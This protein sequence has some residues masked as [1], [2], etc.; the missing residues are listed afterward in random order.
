MQQIDGQ[1]T[2]TEYLKSQMQ[3][4]C[5]A[6]C[7]HCVCRSCLYWWSGRCP[8]GKC[9]DDHRADAD[10]YDKAHPDK[11]P[12]TGWSNWTKPG[13]QAHWCRGGT[14]YPTRWCDHFIKYT[15][16]RV[17]TCIKSNVSIF[18]DGYINCGIMDAIGCEACYQEMKERLDR[19]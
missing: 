2:M 17:E 15:G 12:R 8:Y 11:P 4:I 13:E 7:S 6:G 9:Y 1:I 5:L 18:Q 14:A 16:Q 10:P 19:L 3:M